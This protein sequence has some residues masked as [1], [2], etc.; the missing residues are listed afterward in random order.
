MSE[1]KST[2]SSSHLSAEQESDEESTNQFCNCCGYDGNWNDLFE[3]ESC[4]NW[5]CLK[6]LN[7]ENIAFRREDPFSCPWCLLLEKKQEPIPV[8]V[9]R[10]SFFSEGS[11]QPQLVNSF[12][13][14]QSSCPYQR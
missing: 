2:A 11:H 7:R 1:N 14:F 5:M 9:F 4:K 6:C 10:K 3:C 13:T 12:G 8:A